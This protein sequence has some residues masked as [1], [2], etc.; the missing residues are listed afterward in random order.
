MRLAR[1]QRAITL[2]MASERGLAIFWELVPRFDVVVD[3][4]APHGSGW[5]FNRPQHFPQ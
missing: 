4:F 3:N 5:A 1:L 2:D